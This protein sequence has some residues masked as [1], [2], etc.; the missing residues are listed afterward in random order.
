[1]ILMKHLKK[2]KGSTRYG[3]L[4]EVFK[5]R[6]A[7]SKNEILQKGQSESISALL[8]KYLQQH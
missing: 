6:S 7:A 3:N 1:M 8:L 5:F 4:Q 2:K